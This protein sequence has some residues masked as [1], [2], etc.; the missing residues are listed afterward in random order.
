MKFHLGRLPRLTRRFLKYGFRVS[1]IHAYQRA[2]GIEICFWN[3]GLLI[4]IPRLVKLAKAES[5]LLGPLVTDEPTREV[6]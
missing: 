6:L 3:W 5:D 4:W 1:S 2:V